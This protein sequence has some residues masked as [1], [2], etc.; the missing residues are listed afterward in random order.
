MATPL[1]VPLRMLGWA[2][3]GFALG[4]GWKLGTVVF[5][6]QPA[7]EM[8]SGAKMMIDDGVLEKFNIQSIY[9]LHNFP[10]MP[11]GSMSIMHGA[12]MAAVNIFKITINGK[13]GHAAIPQAAGDSIL[14][15]SSIVTALQSIVSRSIDPNDPVVVSVTSFRS[16]TNAYNIIP[17]TVIMRGTVRYFNPVLEDLIPLRIRSLAENIASGFGVEADVFYEKGCPPTVNTEDEARIARETAKQVTGEE[18]LVRCSPV[19][20]GEDFAFFLNERPGAYGFIG[21]GVDS[22]PLH[23]P[24]YDFNDKILPVGASFFVRLVE[25]VLG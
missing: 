11:E 24:L 7:E 20:I 25:N 6:F 1:L 21:N 12:V 16:S 23:S 8:V 10:G 15:A 17:S 5:L 2:A 3:L 22:A 14:A 18:N 13:G 19:M 4:A 9:G